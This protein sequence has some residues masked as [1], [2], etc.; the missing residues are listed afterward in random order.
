MDN[1]TVPDDS[2]RDGVGRDLGEQVAKGECP[3]ATPLTRQI[4][5]IQERYKQLG[6]GTRLVPWTEED[7]VILAR[8]LWT[9]YSRQHGHAVD[10][11][12]AHGDGAAAGDSMNDVTVSSPYACPELE[13]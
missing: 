8:G 9:P 7:R 6:I 10:A 3:P 1:G 11:G 2:R 13:P 12:Q 5:S 4:D